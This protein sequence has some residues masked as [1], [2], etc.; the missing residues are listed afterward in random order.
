MSWKAPPATRKNSSGSICV[1]DQLAPS[2]AATRME[3]KHEITSGSDDQSYLIDTEVYIRN[4]K[5]SEAEFFA[6]FSWS[7]YRITDREIRMA[8]RLAPRPPLHLLRRLRPP[9]GHVLMCNGAQWLSAQ[10]RQRRIG[11][12]YFP[13]HF[14]DDALFFFFWQGFY[15]GFVDHLFMCLQLHFG[16]LEYSTTALHLATSADIAVWEDQ[17]YI[18][19]CRYC[20]NTFKVLERTSTI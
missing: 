4:K 7:V 10:G 3:K 2:E 9:K 18:K 11:M 17:S 6:N 16:C 5:R 15:L 1:S 8:G 14:L 13:Q 19:K 20:N 12:I